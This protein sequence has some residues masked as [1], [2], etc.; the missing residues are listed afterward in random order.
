MEFSAVDVL[1]YMI[2]AAKANP[3]Y[4]EILLE[5]C[6]AETV[7]LLHQAEEESSAKKFV[8]ALKLA[9]PL[10]ATN[11]ATKYISICAHFFVC[12]HCASDVDKKK[13]DSIILTK[14]TVNGKRIFSDCFVEWIV[15][16]V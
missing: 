13:F 12:W 1:D 11:H 4:C 14:Q 7:F 9:A 3:L 2:N 10:F 6:V 16:D 8:C 5:M 15:K